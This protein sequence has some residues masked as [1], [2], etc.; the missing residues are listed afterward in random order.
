MIM[1][2]Y[3]SMIA[4]TVMILLL[5]GLFLILAW[6]NNHM[7]SKVW[8]EITFPFLNFNGCTVEVCEFISNFIPHSIM[9]YNYLSMLGLK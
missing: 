6:I 9:D 3:L 7:P 5:L 4:K 1:K 8:V 2:I